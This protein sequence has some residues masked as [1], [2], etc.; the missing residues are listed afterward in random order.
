M[1]DPILSLSLSIHANQGVYAL[2]LGSGVSRSAG[3][4]TGWEVVLDL[5][6]KLALLSSE[7]CQPD[8]ATWYRN[9]YQE[10]PNYSK[11]IDLIAKS[12]SERSQ[13]LKNYFEPTSEDR[14]QGLKMP[15]ATHRAIASLVAEGYIRVILTTNFDRLMEKALEEVG[16]NPTVI[17]TPDA[18]NGA[19]PLTHTKCSIIK[20]HGDYLDTR[21]KNTPT[22]LEQ[23]DQR[24][25]SLLDRV[26][27]EFGLIVCGWSGEWDTALRSAIE[28]CPNRRFTTYWAAR[29]E[30]K[31]LAKDLFG[32]R[33]GV[34]VQIRDADSFFE[35]LAEKVFALQELEKPH[36]L[37]AKV[38]VVRLKKDLVEDRY[39]IRLH[40]LVMQEVEKVYSELSSNRFSLSIPHSPE[41][42][43]QRVKDYESVTEILVAMMVTGCYWGEESHEY[44][45][46]D[47]LERVA[48]VHEPKTGGSGTKI[49]KSLSL[50]PA[51]VI[52]Y[53]GGI[54]AIASGRYDTFAGLL[55]QPQVR[56]LERSKPP[57]FALFTLSIMDNKVAEKLLNEGGGRHTPLSDYLHKILRE[58]LRDFLPQED[59]Y[60][61]CFDR[62]EYLLALV[63][64]DWYE[65]QLRQFWGPIGSFGWR[66]EI[67]DQIAQESL[68]AGED[69]L[70]LK[71]GLFNGSGKRF[72]LVQA[73]FHQQLAEQTIRW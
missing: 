13:L 25:D 32:L 72:Q 56:E 4:P 19:M 58:P 21:I 54:A 36:P 3:I 5:I 34:F 33:G 2:L 60:T 59:R 38:A 42:L 46:I 8:A 1:I 39:R 65:K 50:Y 52:L 62:F 9:K 11:L 14:E 47:T 12:P 51:L 48:N 67:V 57:A 6:R 69:W 27:D 30:P 28:R 55:I 26:F 44:L 18:I 29:R 40:D 15:T 41:A 45:W 23:Y 63:C 49:W 16:I 66:R 24:L 22:E 73:N 7:D 53:A 68:K 20:M 61:K 70:L 17:D 31:G 10:E 43:I 35:E 37:S 64:S 71:A